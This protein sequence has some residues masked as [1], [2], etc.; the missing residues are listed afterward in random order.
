MDVNACWFE[1]FGD[2]N[3]WKGH[4]YGLGFPL[5][6]ITYAWSHYIGRRE[7]GGHVK[8]RENTSPYLISVQGFPHLCVCF[9]HIS[10]RDLLSFED[11]LRTILFFIRLLILLFFH[12]FASLS[13]GEP[14]TNQLDW[15]IWSPVSI[16]LFPARHTSVEKKKTI[17]TYP[18]HTNSTE[19]KWL[20]YTLCPIIFNISCYLQILIISYEQIAD[21]INTK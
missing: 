4:D 14:Q 2:F 15:P 19:Q 6:W 21:S 1:S 18:T 8:D 7:H 11:S 5:A 10:V 12:Y 3:L 13:C 17:R 20:F 16:G 9:T